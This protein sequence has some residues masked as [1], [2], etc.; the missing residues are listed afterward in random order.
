[1][2]AGV[3]ACIIDGALK[4]GT[5]VASLG[6][7]KS[8]LVVRD[9]GTAR[10]F[11][12]TDGDSHQDVGTAWTNFDTHD[13]VTVLN[14]MAGYLARPGNEIKESFGGW[15]KQSKAELEAMGLV[16]FNEDLD[17]HAFV[18]MSKLTMLL[19]GAVRQMGLQ[20]ES[21]QKQLTAQPK[22]LPES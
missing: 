4:S 14:S 7:D 1:T 21:M 3:G 2:T 12:D 6:A 18:N 13:D 19:V 11:L 9:N 8:I 22:L 17:G 10:F 5:G 16:R 20:I 15:L